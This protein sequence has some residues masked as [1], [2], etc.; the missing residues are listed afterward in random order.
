MLAGAI[1][2]ESPNGFYNEYLQEELMKHKR[3]LA[4]LGSRMK[5]ASDDEQLSGVGFSTT[6]KGSVVIRVDDSKIFKIVFN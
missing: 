5:V 4:A 6:R 1:N 3:V 2:D